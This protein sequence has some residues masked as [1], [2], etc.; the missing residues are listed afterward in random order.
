MNESRK[1]SVEWST[2]WAYKW[3]IIVVAILT[4]G[5]G[6]I[7]LQITDP[8]YEA[9]TRI[10]VQQ[11]GYPLDDSK[12][13]QPDKQFAAT[14]AEV[15]RSPLVVRRALES[16]AIK[17]ESTDE[18]DPV[19]KTLEDLH[20]APVVQTD[21]VTLR[22]RHKDPQHAVALIKAIIASYQDHLQEIES[23]SQNETLEILS[24]RERELRQEMRRL[25]AEHESLREESPL[26]GQARDNLDLHTAMLTELT[27]QLAQTRTRRA[28]LENQLKALQERTAMYVPQP[29]VEHRVQFDASLTEECGPEGLTDAFTAESPVAL[30]SP[31]EHTDIVRD[32]ATAMM[33]RAQNAVVSDDFALLEQQL[34]AAKVRHKQLEQKYGEKHPEL[35]SV[36]AEINKLEQLLRDRLLATVTWLG[37]EVVNETAAEERLNEIYGTEQEKFKTLDGYLLRDEMIR[38]EIARTEEFYNSTMAQLT[39]VRLIDQAVAEGRASVVVRDLEGPNLHPERVWPQPTRFLGLCA[40]V[41]LIGGV[42]LAY[43]REL[44]KRVEPDGAAALEV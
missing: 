5:A 3:H 26:V 2:L 41:G 25:Q 7:Y 22:Y 10:L 40:I 31:T 18:G 38:G 37:Q 15:I 11:V 27:Q 13:V 6:A 39:N 12:S 33:V 42:L 20:V 14:Q 32:E 30:L 16:L 29:D 43:G 1:L 19:I 17:P 34:R 8:A 44:V 36:A 35:K 28:G 4:V 21:V 24:R 9:E 23:N